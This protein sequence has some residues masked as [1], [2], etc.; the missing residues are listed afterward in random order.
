MISSHETCVISCDEIF[1][2]Y[3]YTHIYAIMHSTMCFG[4]TI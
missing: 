3:L 2:T 4:V 1:F